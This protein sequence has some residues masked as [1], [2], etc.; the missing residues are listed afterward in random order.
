MENLEEN[1]DINGRKMYTLTYK[2]KLQ[3]IREL[4]NGKKLGK[5]AA[6]YGI[7]KSTIH[8][9]Y[10]DRERIRNICQDTPVSS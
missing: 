1:G 6:E 8:Y 9:I 3:V 10:K 5:V 2:E 4:E 7:G